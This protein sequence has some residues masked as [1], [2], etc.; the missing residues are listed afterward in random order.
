MGVEGTAERTTGRWHWPLAGIHTYLTALALALLLPMLAFAGLLALR[1][2]DAERRVIEAQRADITNNLH[3]LVDQELESIAALLR[4]LAASPDLAAG[5]FG[6]FEVHTTRAASIAGIDRIALSDPLGRLVPPFSVVPNIRTI[7]A[8][9]LQIVLAGNVAVSKGRF[10]LTPPVGFLLSVPV[11]IEGTVRYALSAAVAVERMQPLFANARLRQDWVGAIFDRQGTVLARNRMK[12]QFV[13]QPA[14]AEAIAA[15]QG[16]ATEGV[17]SNATL[18][19]INSSTAFRRSRY[20]WTAVV[21]VPTTVLN[22][23]LNRALTML[24]I[25]GLVLSSL[26]LALAYILGS[27]IANAAVALQ[28][29]AAAVVDGHRPASAE[30]SIAELRDI[31]AAFVYAADVAH[32]KKAADAR[33]R[34]S[35]ERL[36]LALAA[37]SLGTWDLDVRTGTARWSNTTF[38]ILGYEPNPFG[39][40][41]MQMW[42]DQL[43]PDERATMLAQVEWAKASR[44]R[45]ESEHR[46]VRADTGVTSWIRKT[47]EFH[48]DENGT[49]VRF[50]GVIRDI[51]ERKTIE[52]ELLTSQARYKSALQVGRIGSWET[53]FDTGQRIWS[54]EGEALFGL[55]LKGGIGHVGGPNDEYRAALHPEDR[56]LVERFHRLA[57]SQDTFESEYRIAGRDGKVAW[58]AGRGHVVARDAN[59]RARRL[60]SVVADITARKEAERHVTF[61]M[62]EIAH[63]SKNLLSVVQAIAGQTA[64]SAQSVKDFDARFR[65]RLHALAASNDILVSQDWQHASLDTLVKK[66]LAPFVGDNWHRIDCGGP[67]FDVDANAA[68]AIGL[69]LH[70]LATNAAKYGA[71]STPEGRLAVRWSV[72][73][74]GAQSETTIAWIE[75]GGPPVVAPTRKGFGQT[76]MEQMVAQAVGG[77]VKLEYAPAGLCWSLTWASAATEHGG[78]PPNEYV[79]TTGQIKPSPSKATDRASPS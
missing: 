70:E 55:R 38:Q 29:D 69:A 17:F 19:G 36:R 21:A 73:A 53:N 20:G 2:A 13:G 33:L 54:E 32:E 62:Q 77:T 51:T 48:Y 72:E 25:T 74:S 39:R 7:D 45:Y 28:H 34:D 49:A 11:V 1:Y 37:G 40:A 16:V 64:R 68:Q 47:G 60:V 78:T 42:R 27:R 3:D 44:Q 24:G 57:H 5:R 6:E 63:R 23:P 65:K 18:E 22:A 66:Q 43:L 31:T 9:D 56:H 30:H 35:E 71:L 67:E 26:G 8:S 59:G 15:A 41:S 61:L 58:V 79:P 10:D 4:G 46:I 50:V 52:A 12:E 76:V 75:S 14:R